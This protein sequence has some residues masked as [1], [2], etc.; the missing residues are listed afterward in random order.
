M[1]C[2][3]GLVRRI[4]YYELVNCIVEVSA[5]CRRSS[6]HDSVF[7]EMGFLI[8]L[9]PI[10]NFTDA[11]VGMAVIQHDGG[12]KPQPYHGRDPPSTASSPLV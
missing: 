4:Y 7:A 3:A 6:G 8:F 1:Q 9:A 12:S 5:N 11:D 10:S 2:A